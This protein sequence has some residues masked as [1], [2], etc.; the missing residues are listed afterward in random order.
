MAK[1]AWC[2]VTPTSGKEN[3]TI[4]ISATAHT[5]RLARTTTVTVQ[6]ANGTKPSA[7]I[8]VSQ[9]GG[10]STTMDATKPDI[11]STG[12]TFIVN[13]SSNSSKL[14]FQITDGTNGGTTMPAIIVKSISVTVNGAAITSNAPIA[15]DPG[16]A[17]PYNFVATVVMNAS[18]FPTDALLALRIKDD[19]EAATLC[20]FTYKGTSTL[21][22][23]TSTL[24][25]T[26]AGTAQ[27]VNITSN[28]NWTVS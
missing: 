7:A 28:D 14:S 4:N 21:S 19:S 1:A 11:P 17:A 25:L 22:A 5:G 2:T 12:G 26:K 24:S 9:A 8:T 3:G 16:A 6:A 10:V 23:S 15:G 18:I 27:A 13:G 20:K